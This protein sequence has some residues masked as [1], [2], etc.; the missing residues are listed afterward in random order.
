MTSGR[1]LLTSRGGLFRPRLVERLSDPDGFRVAYLVAPAGSG[2]SVLLAQIANSFPGRIAWCG[3]APAHATSEDDVA[4]WIGDALAGSGPFDGAETPASRR[5]SSL[6]ELRGFKAPGGKPLLVAVD[7]A[8]LLSDGEPRQA[9]CGLVESL[10]QDWRLIVASR[11]RLSADVSRLEVGGDFVEYGPDDLRF[12][13]WEVEDLFRKVYSE[14]LLP[15]QAA[16][17]T[18]RTSGWAAYLQLF[19]LATTR[20]PET[21]RRELMEAL[22]RRVKLVS[23][24]LGRHVLDGLEP[25]LAEFLLTSAVLRRP[26]PQSCSELLGCEADEA[27]AMLDELERRQI[28]TERVTGD[29]FRYHSVLVSYLDAKLVAAV[30]LEAA[31][32][33]H[34]RAAGILE[35]RGR[36]D[37]ALEA[38]VRCE[39]WESVRRLI[40]EHRY[41]AGESD[42]GHANDGTLSDAVDEMLVEAVPGSMLDSDPLMMMSVSSRLLR[43]GNLLQAAS[44]LRRAE[45]V[46]GSAEL[47]GACRDMHHKVTVWLDA[48]GT[49]ESDPAGIVR[50]ATCRKPLSAVQQAAGI[51]GSA[52]RVVEGICYLIAG[53][54]L[55]A[56]RLLRSARSAPDLPAWSRVL[57]ALAEH[58]AQ[59][60]VGEADADLLA[61]SDRLRDEVEHLAIPWFSR[62]AEVILGS[63]GEPAGTGRIDELLAACARHGDVWGEALI[64]LVAGLRG[65][66]RRDLDAP[67]RLAEAAEKFSALGAHVLH[68]QSVAAGCL[69]LR[70]F[71]EVDL[72]RSSARQVRTLADLY[73]VP[74]AAAVAATILCEVEGPAAGIDEAGRRLSRLGLG[75]VVSKLLAAGPVAAGTGSEAPAGDD[76]PA[77][78][79]ASAQA[80]RASQRPPVD[81]RCLG[82]FAMSV[83]GRSVDETKLK[84]MERAI[85]HLLA[86]RAGKAIHREELIVALW[87]DA[88]IETAKHRLQVALSS[89]RRMLDAHGQASHLV[90]REA[91]SYRLDLPA[92]SEADVAAFKA[93][94]SQA[95]RAQTSGDKALEIDSLRIAVDAYAGPLLPGDGPADWVVDQRDRLQ[96]EFVDACLRLADILADSGDNDAAAAVARR[97]LE[98]DKY[99]DRL[100][101]ILI[102][103]LEASQRSMQARKARDDYDNML[104]DLGISPGH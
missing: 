102:G 76:T 99:H 57:A 50:S 18:R 96:G 56:T 13:S 29:A 83:A 26:D 2:K 32:E 54:F 36:Y 59:C 77:A 86:M 1:N 52:G 12:R 51:A 73:D 92:G 9:L 98:V 80:G 40:R 34:C 10:P 79:A 95:R 19:Y 60:C 63:S 4:R 49:S 23:D 55:A 6:E 68:A 93:A 25:H 84:P 104:R 42:D 97:G 21:Q 70:A 39:D 67:A 7:D 58:A 87:P 88:D 72:A 11:E 24:Y 94:I 16:T 47:A 37:E 17:L 41:P 38:Y 5:V 74:A 61:Q 82:G 44:V 14:P 62:L 65:L 53:D 90:V 30:G 35:T 43:S 78:P 31:K 103:S 8:H 45:I 33:Q 66:V 85:L 100:W 81:L 15:E 101:R 28:F 3:P 27:R 69:A 48:A 20:K 91:D 89:I 64:S 75:D 71:G 46:A 22:T